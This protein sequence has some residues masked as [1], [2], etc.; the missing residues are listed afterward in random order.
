[1]LKQLKSDISHHLYRLRPWHHMV[2]SLVNT[3]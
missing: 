2:A 3:K 1:V